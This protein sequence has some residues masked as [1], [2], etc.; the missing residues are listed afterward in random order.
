MIA[1]PRPAECGAPSLELGEGFTEFNMGSVEFLW[2]SANRE[3]LVV[4]GI[5][6][7][8]V[9]VSCSIDCFTAHTT[10]EVALVFF[11]QDTLVHNKPSL[12]V[13]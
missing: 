7:L 10:G 1:G 4:M 13:Q 6:F 11:E 5:D 3:I 12:A 2:N 8:N 9:A